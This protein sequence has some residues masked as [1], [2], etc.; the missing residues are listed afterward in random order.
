MLGR[1]L[2]FIRDHRAN[3]APMFGLLA[4]P[5]VAMTGAAIDYSRASSARMKLASAVDS[6]T[7][8]LGREAIMS[9]EDAVAFIEQ[10]VAATLAGTHYEGT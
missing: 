10:Y 1:L 2:A 3:V 4:I 8:A 9:D 5:L 6:A 7:L